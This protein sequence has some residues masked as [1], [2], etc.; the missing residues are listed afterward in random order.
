VWEFYSGIQMDGQV[1]HIGVTFSLTPRPVAVTSERIDPETVS[2]VFLL[3]RMS[4]SVTSARLTTSRRIKARQRETVKTVHGFL[5]ATFT[6]INR[7]VTERAIRSFNRLKAAAAM[8]FLPHS[9]N[10]P[11]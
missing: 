8:A 9:P 7:G 2:T 6:A 1:E 10:P 5:A 3:A 4:I 11:I